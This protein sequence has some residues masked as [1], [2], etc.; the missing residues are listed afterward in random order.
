M[1]RPTLHVIQNYLS[2]TENWVYEYI[3]RHRRYP[4]LV[5]TNRTQNL[6]L[7]GL[8]NGKIASLGERGAWQR[9]RDSL[10]RRLG[11]PPYASAVDLLRRSGALVV[12]AHFGDIGWQHL[13]LAERG[14]AALVT[15]F[16]G[17]DVSMLPREAL[18]RER[19]RE[20]FARGARF[21]AL[22]PEMAAALRELGCPAEKIAVIPLGI[23]L[24]R[25]RYERRGWDG[26]PINALMVASFVPKKG[27]LVALEALALL[28]PEFPTL[29]LHLVGDGELRPAIEA[30]IERLGLAGA[31]TLHGNVPYATAG[32]LGDQAHLF[33]LPSLT[34]PDGNQEG[35]PTVLIEAQARGLPVVATRHAGI[36]SVVREGASGFLAEENDVAS[37][38]AAWRALLERPAAWPELGATGRAIVEE[39]YDAAK[40]AL[41]FEDLYAEVEATR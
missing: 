13:W 25:F 33:V 14:G 27:H 40:Q 8:P 38:A 9:G 4:P 5:L 15:S 35:L 19:Y 41:K 16:Y 23:D 10:V 6:E 21:I 2:V 28:L 20:L 11:G 30:A 22:A 17:Y 1:T 7:F 39:S 26:G 34:A 32:E 31:V 36:P 24:G 12:H 29:R 18:W 3:R 37:L